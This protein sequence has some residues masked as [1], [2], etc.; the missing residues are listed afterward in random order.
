MAKVDLSDLTRMAGEQ[1]HAALIEM[2]HDTLMPMYVLVNEKR[3][4]TVIACPWRNNEEKAAAVV[5]VKGQA[6][7][8]KATALSFLSEVW[9]TTTAEAPDAL[10]V[11]PSEHPKRREYVIACA[12]DGKTTEMRRWQIVRDRPGGSII[13]LVEETMEPGM[14]QSRLLD[15]ILPKARE[16]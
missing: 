7:R 1:A 9:M 16:D 11:A 4:S 12:T 15:D 3:E 13:A 5:E 8:L 2:R 10:R 6:A 14:F